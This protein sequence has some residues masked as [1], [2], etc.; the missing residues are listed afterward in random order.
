[1]HDWINTDPAGLGFDFG[2]WYNVHVLDPWSQIANLK[3]EYAY[4]GRHLDRHDLKE[5]WSSYL[6]V[7]QWWVVLGTESRNGAS[8]RLEN[9]KR[10]GKAEQA[11]A[12][13]EQQTRGWRVLLSELTP[14]QQGKAQDLERECMARALEKAKSSK[15][16][17]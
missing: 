1:M 14:L 12:R 7:N 8:D 5:R 16:P 9:W 11:P 10:H 17:S 6:Q 2:G 4:A 13:N 15:N 3:A